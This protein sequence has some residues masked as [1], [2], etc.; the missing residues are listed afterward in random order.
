MTGFAQ[1][2]SRRT[3]LPTPLPCRCLRLRPEP[4]RRR[5]YP[6]PSGMRMSHADHWSRANG[7]P[8]LRSSAADL[9]LLADGNFD[10]VGPARHLVEF[11]EAHPGARDRCN[12]LDRDGDAF[13]TRRPARLLW[14]SLETG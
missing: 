13:G 6:G 9:A 8:R 2:S 14:R 11:A 7:K 12:R 5:A 1:T 10:R 4:L 3:P